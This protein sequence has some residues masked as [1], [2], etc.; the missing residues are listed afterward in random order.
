M[1]AGKAHE[2][3]G[4]RVF[5]FEPEMGAIGRGAGKMHDPCLATSGGEHVTS[6]VP[7]TQD[8][9]PVHCPPQQG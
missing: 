7:A 6:H 3:F 8:S 1:P 9:D 5:T 2:S 4:R